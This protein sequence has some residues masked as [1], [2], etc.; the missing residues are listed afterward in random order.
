[1]PSA[2]A[3]ASFTGQYRSDESDMTYTVHIVDGKLM[4]SWSRQYDV[5]LEAVGGDR[6]L[7][8]R[9]T[10]TFT[11]NGSGEVDGLTISNRRLRRFRVER[12]VAAEVAKD[13]S[14]AVVA[15]AHGH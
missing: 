4:F 3:L 5:A 8:S 1:M 15:G 14:G 7:G 9:G 13:V 2:A 6:F 11:R 10:I 12:V